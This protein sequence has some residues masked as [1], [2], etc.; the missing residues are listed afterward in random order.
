MSQATRLLRKLYTLSP[1]KVVRKV[2]GFLSRPKS[3]SPPPITEE[4]LRSDEYREIMSRDL[5]FDGL[6]DLHEAQNLTANFGRLL[7]KLY[8]LP[9]RLC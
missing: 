2:K 3:E 1:E 5:P 8:Y 7:G 4:F 6:Y 9:C